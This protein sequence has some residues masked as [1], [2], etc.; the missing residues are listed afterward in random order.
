MKK[1]NFEENRTKETADEALSQKDSIL[2]IKNILDPEEYKISPL[3]IPT[4]LDD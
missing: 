4:D 3:F 1:N 2:D